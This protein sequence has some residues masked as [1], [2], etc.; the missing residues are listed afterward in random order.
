MNF[1]ILHADQMNSMA[2]HKPAQPN[3]YYGGHFVPPGVTYI[4]PQPQMQNYPPY[5]EGFPNYYFP[6]YPYYQGM[7]QQAQMNYYSSFANFPSQQGSNSAT[8]FVN[9][10]SFDYLNNSY[11]K[12]SASF[13]TNASIP[14]QG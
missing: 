7:P 4:P 5:A 10:S 14:T 13:E 9:K 12:G 2:P 6:Y 3:N 11:S 1:N 8:P